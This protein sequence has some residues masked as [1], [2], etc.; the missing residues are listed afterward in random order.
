ML[1]ALICHLLLFLQGSGDTWGRASSTLPF[2]DFIK[3]SRLF[4][5]CRSV[6]LKLKQKG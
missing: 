5:S 1:F 3:P 2:D 4:L 6:D